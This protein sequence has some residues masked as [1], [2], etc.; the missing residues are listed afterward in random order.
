MAVLQDMQAEMAR[1]Q[2]ELELTKAKL[3]ARNNRAITCKV[4]EKGAL[5]IYGLGRFPITLYLSQ[6]RK[7]VDNWQTIAQFVEENEDQ[8]AT[9]D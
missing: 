3:A 8:F 9:K 7:L 2:A 5:S 4:S 1:L 6:Y